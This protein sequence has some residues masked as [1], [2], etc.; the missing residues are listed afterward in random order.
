MLKELLVSAFVGK[1]GAR[2]II[3]GHILSYCFRQKVYNDM[4]NDATVMKTLND[5][6]T[7]HHPLNYIYLG[8]F[9]CMLIYFINDLNYKKSF[10]KIKNGVS[11]DVV[12]K[13]EFVLLFLYFVFTRDVENAF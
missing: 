2:V 12:H 6:E 7:N 9:P 8:L 5:I 11:K 13:I 4:F 10:K 1:S 3:S